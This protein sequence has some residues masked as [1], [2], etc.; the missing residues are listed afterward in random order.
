MSTVYRQLFEGLPALSAL[1]ANSPLADSRELQR[2]V[3]ALPLA[4]TAH[5]ARMLLDML[6][7]L[8]RSQLDT[9]SRLDALEMLRRP[10]AQLTDSIDRQIVVAAFPLPPAKAQL[11]AIAREIQYEL[12]Q[13]YRLVVVEY[14]R[15]D[16][17]IPFLRGKQVAIALRRALDYLGAEL[18]RG[19]LSYCAP[20]AG[21]WRAAHALYRFA[22]ESKLDDRSVGDGL[23]DA[24]GTPQHAYAHMLLLAISNPFRLQLREILDAYLVTR[25]WARQC[26]FG[27]SAANAIAIPLEED[28]GPGYLPEERAGGVGRSLSLDLAPIETELDRLIDFNA[29]HGGALTFSLKG[30]APVAVSVELA[31]RLMQTWKPRSDRSHVRLPAQHVLDTLIGLHAVHYYLAGEVDF[32]SFV[33][34][35][36]GTATRTAERDRAAAWTANALDVGRPEILSSLVQDQSIG[37]YRLS[38]E[39]AGAMKARVGEVIAL[40]LGGSD[41]R[42]RDWMVGVIRWLRM[43]DAGLVEAG[44]ELLG[45]QARPAVLRAL[46]QNGHPKPSV[47][48]LRLEAALNGSH[49]PEYSV[50][51]PSVVERGAPRYELRSAPE[52][53]ADDGRVV[54]DHFTQLGVIEQPGTYLRIGPE[55]A[56]TH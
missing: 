35:I 55:R 26:R 3:D 8:G 27:P 49:S 34:R 53:Y 10:T 47:R 15:P 52:R 40:A 42:E 2:W 16:G 54:I 51:V 24:D 22:Q 18:A 45:R 12:A 11:A 39:N 23:G 29:A 31:R 14:C 21:R 44:V 33:R 6:R 7:L 56:A 25:V 28:R 13:T 30:G 48:A 19:Y 1:P 46:D 17:R 38:W 36:C 4:N 37:G 50:L 9:G 43:G 5:A 41:A 20:P 32:E